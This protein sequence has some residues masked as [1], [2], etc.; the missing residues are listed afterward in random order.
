MKTIESLRKLLSALPNVPT[1]I[2]GRHGRLFNDYVAPTYDLMRE[3][4]ID[5]ISIFKDAISEVERPF[6]EIDPEERNGNLK[7]Q[8]HEMADAIWKRR[9]IYE[10]TRNLLRAQCEAYISSIEIQE[11]KRYFVT[12]CEYFIYDDDKGSIKTNTYMDFTIESLIRKGGLSTYD[13]PTTKFLKNIKSAD[14][15]DEA[16][17]NINIILERMNR[18]YVSIMIAYQQVLDQRQLF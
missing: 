16:V 7:Q 18:K 15:L 2:P 4:H 8:L 10:K 14:S 6:L 12:V 9:K 11:F 13:T 17:G 5:Y 1:T 3:I